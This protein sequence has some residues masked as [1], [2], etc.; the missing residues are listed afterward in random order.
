[1]QKLLK[2]HK[3]KKTYNK[4]LITQLG[5][6]M[7]TIEYKNNRRMCDIFVGPGNGPVLLGM[8]D[9]ATL[10]IIN[11]N[12]DSLEAE[13]A[14]R[15]NCNRNTADAKISNAKQEI[16]EAR[17]YCTNMDGI[18]KNTNNRSGPAAN[19]NANTLTNYFLSY[20][21]VE[22]DKRKSTELT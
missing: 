8:P 3:I 10:N 12:I 14:Q 19:T 6:W 20:P 16:H 1:M 21:N 11:R 5:T 18:L 2:T 22:T 7:V 9:T 15:D 17:K 4:T 13:D